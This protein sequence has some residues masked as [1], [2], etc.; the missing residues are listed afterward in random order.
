MPPQGL[1][2]RK[3]RDTWPPLQ[4]PAGLPPVPLP[5]LCLGR[6]PTLSHGLGGW[7]CRRTSEAWK[8]WHWSQ[9]SAEVMRPGASSHHTLSEIS[10]L[11]Q[12]VWT[13]LLK[14]TTKQKTENSKMNK[15]KQAWYWTVTKTIK[16]NKLIKITPPWENHQV[17]HLLNASTRK[18]Y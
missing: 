12:P 9:N 2:D 14:Q 7:H 11:D 18:F 4:G 17:F 3:M 10:C 16:V 5:T 13:S 15:L 1:A 6:T 8:T